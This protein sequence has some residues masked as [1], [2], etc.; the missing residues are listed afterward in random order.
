MNSIERSDM[1]HW[2]AQLKAV[3]GLDATLT[4]LPG[5][6]DLNFA[7]DGARPAVLKVM[8]EGCAPEFVGLQVALH[9][10]IAAGSAGAVPVPGVIAARDGAMQVVLDGPDGTRR[11]AWL[12]E[13]L[14]GLVVGQVRP[15]APRLFSDVGTAIARLA[16]ALADFEHPALARK[17]KWDLRRSDWIAGHMA[18]IDSPSRRAQIEAILQA[19]KATLQP[20]LA[21]IPVQAIHNDL[22]DYNLLAVTDATGESRLSGLIDFGDAIRAPVLCDLAIAGAY[23]VLDTDRPLE[24]LAALVRGF[25]AERPLSGPEIDALWGLVLTRLAVSVINAAIEKTARPGDPYVTISERP[26]WEFLDRARG[27]DAALARAHLR[28]AAGHA[29]FPA[30]SRL[31]QAI[32]AAAP[33]PVLGPLPRTLRVADLS[34]AGGDAPADP[35]T[36]A[37]EDFS[38]D[39]GDAATAACPVIGRYGEARLIYTA[40]MFRQ[41]AHPAGPRRSVHLGVDVFLPAGAAVMAPFDGAVLHAGEEPGHQGYGGVVV[42]RHVLPDGTRFAAL[43]GH[44]RPA[45]A[46]ALTPGQAIRRGETFA[47]LG[48]AAENGGWPAHL[49]LQM[50]LP[51]DAASTWPGIFDP[52]LEAPARAVFPNPAPLLGLDPELTACPVL[53]RDAEIARRKRHSA[54]N[55]KLFY[56]RPLAVLRGRGTL[57]YDERGRAYLDA[58][59]NV[60]HV[61]HAHPRVTE[62]VTRQMR[63]VNTNSRYLQPIHG[64]YAEALAARLPDGLD[65]VFFVNSGSEAND[66]AL[67]LA[68][69]ATGGTDFVVSRSGYHGITQSAIDISEYKFSG[70]GGAGQPRH[71]HTA[72]IPDTFRGPFGAGDPEAGQRY[73]GDVARAIAGAEAQGRRIAAFISEPFPSVGGQIVPPAGY[74]RAVYS[75]VRA[76]GGLCIADEVQTGLGRLGQ[77]FWGF[78]AQGAMPDIVVLGKPVANGHPMGVVLTTRVI[79]DALAPGMEFFSTF[80]GSSVSCAAGLAVLE[81]LDAERLPAQAETVGGHIVDGL[82]ALARQHPVL[83]DVRGMGLFLGVD[84]CRANG[85]PATEAAAYIVNRL[86][87]RRILIGSDGPMDNVLKIR[88]PLPFSLADADH[89]LSVLS[90]VLRETPLDVLTASD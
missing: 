38:A 75:H 57:L 82:R 3:W 5:E 30:A 60:P 76:A 62:A 23:A 32:A 22:N 2:Q 28:E 83:G 17:L 78:E 61:G 41:G 15:R 85:A 80:G 31:V 33:H 54:A 19:F 65:V 10:H 47:T 43:Y 14:P 44:L 68:R 66:L 77:T 8:R 39:L 86:R 12:V 13:R 50:G 29:P 45:D 90:D 59:N 9:A 70:P 89:L 27:I 26:A 58:Y 40:P 42:L 18:L 72:M 49:H 36:C 52:D 56:H 67:R 4:P 79:A 71:V 48:T 16:A 88:P 21:E 34:V 74:L 64:A 25:V 69:A 1:S 84:L 63:L 24:T 81:V 55:L 20:L 6:L 73:A 35:E 46:L 51:E 7:V 53:D 11:Q 37:L 87:E